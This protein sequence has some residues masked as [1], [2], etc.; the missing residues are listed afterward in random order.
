MGGDDPCT[1]ADG[2]ADCAE[3]CDESSKTCT[4][5]DPDG[6]VCMG[7]ACLGGTCVLGAGNGCTSGSECESGFCVDGLCCAEASCG[8]Y[9]CGPGGIC[10]DSCETSGDCATGF[11]CGADGKCKAD[12]SAGA[13]EESSGVPCSQAG[14]M[15]ATHGW[16]LG[17]SQLDSCDAVEGLGAPTL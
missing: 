9:V 8:A 5:S 11:S 15:A 16:C 6:A 4:A 7:G 1:P 14:R 13:A 12:G 3:S 2:D 17:F 10:L